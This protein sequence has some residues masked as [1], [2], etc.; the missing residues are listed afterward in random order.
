MNGFDP[1]E[2]LTPLKDRIVHTHAKDARRAPRFAGGDG[3]AARATA[4]STGWSISAR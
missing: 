4:T 2:N 3:G 1:V